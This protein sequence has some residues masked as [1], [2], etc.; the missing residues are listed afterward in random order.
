[1]SKVRL[2]LGG[3]LAAILQFHCRFRIWQVSRSVEKIKFKAVL[4]WVM[5][6]DYVRI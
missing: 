2:N 6:S 4:V 3:G 1:M 5:I